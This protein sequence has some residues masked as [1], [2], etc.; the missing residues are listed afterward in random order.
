VIQG[1]TKPEVLVLLS[2]GVD[3]TACLD[4]Y[5]DL[6][7]D[8]CALFVGHGQPAERHE[9]RAARAI[10]SHYG[11]SIACL[12]MMQARQKT[13][14]LIS[15]RNAFL[16]TTAMMERPPSVSVVAV[17]IHAGTGYADCSVEFVEGMQTVLDLYSEGLQLVA[18]FLEWTKANI[19]EY[20]RLKDVPLGLTYSCERGL[21]SPCGECL[22]CLDRKAL[23]ARA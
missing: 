15:G 9:A 18:P 6:G 23:D 21:A 13:S 7:C 10:A 14:G 3:S 11:V 12:R 4:F 19:L 5:I 2:G 1:R 20:C 17:G 16:V 8:P 22:S